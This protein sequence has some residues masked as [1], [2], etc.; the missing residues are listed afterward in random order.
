M[1]AAGDA[2][3]GG[4]GAAVGGA[5]RLGFSAGPA[6]LLADAQAKAAATAAIAR[7]A[8]MARGCAD[9]AVSVKR[10][11]R[12]AAQC[13]AHGSARER[14]GSETVNVVPSSAEDRA[15]ISPPCAS[16]ICRTM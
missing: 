3:E 12:R 9:G 11:A 7:A 4:A 6:W 1:G 13:G 8:R 2:V 16:T 5:A 14:R 10:R 15:E